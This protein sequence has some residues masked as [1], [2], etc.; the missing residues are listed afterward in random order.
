MEKLRNKQDFPS[1]PEQS[2]NYKFTSRGILIH[3]VSNVY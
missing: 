2:K 1:M 3:G